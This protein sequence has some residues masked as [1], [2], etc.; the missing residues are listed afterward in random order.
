MAT[1]LA[2]RIVMV[3]A[4]QAF[5]LDE[6]DLTETERTYLHDFLSQLSVLYGPVPV[7]SGSRPEEKRRTRVEER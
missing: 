6:I 7:F 4:D 1:R 3:V 5:P 2:L